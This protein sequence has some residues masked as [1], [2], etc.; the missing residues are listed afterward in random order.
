[1]SKQST[2]MPLH[3]SILRDRLVDRLILGA[4]LHNDSALQYYP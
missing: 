2:G 3:K 4:V 1:M